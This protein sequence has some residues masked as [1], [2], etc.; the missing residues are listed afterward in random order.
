MNPARLCPKL[1]SAR[2]ALALAT[3]VSPWAGQSANAAAYLWDS[4][5]GL[6]TAQ[7]GGGTWDAT[8]ANW[9]NAG[10]DVVWA[11]ANDAT[12]G[13]GTDGTYAVSVAL[14]PT[15]NSLIFNNS[16]YT[17]SAAAPQTVTVGSA[18]AALVLG[19]GKS[20]TIGNNVTVTTS[21]VNQNSVI[22]GAGTLTIESGGTLR[23]AGTVNTNILSINGTTV[24]VK[25]G[26]TV[27][28][29]PLVT[30]GTALFLNGTMNVT[31]GT[32]TVPG[33]LGLGQSTG[34]AAGT[35][36]I[37]SGT[38]TANSSNGLRIGGT[39]GT[40][41]GGT[42]NL[43]GGT[44]AALM[45]FKGAGTVT[46]SVL[47]LNGGT[48]QATAANTTFISA[49]ARAN[50]RNGG[51]LINSNGFN[52]T[53]P[54]ALLHSNVG[55]DAPTDGGLVKSGSGTLTLNGLNTYNGGTTVNGG[56]VQ[57][58]AG[59][60]PSAGTITINGGGALVASGGF[61]TVAAVLASPNVSHGSSGAVALAGA[62]SENISF[63]SFSNLMLG[64]S[65]AS[66]Y[67]GTLTPAGTTYRL[68][69]GGSALTLANLNALT[70]ANDVVIGAAG[71]TGTVVLAT[72]NDYTGSTTITSGTLQLGDGVS[73]GSIGSTSS[74]V[75]NGT[76][77]FNTVGSQATGQSISGTGSL[78]KQGIGTLTLS[79]ASNYS[80]TTTISGG[81]LLVTNSGALGTSG[82]TASVT[83]AQL[84]LSDNVSL[85]N[86]VR[87]TSSG[88]GTT[89]GILK[90]ISGS[91]TLSDFGFSGT[92][93]TR[94]HV[95]AGST[96]LMPN[97]FATGNVSSFRVI[98]AGTLNLGGNNG[99]A[100]GAAQLFLLGDGT[101]PGPTVRAGND[102][103][104][105][106][107]Q[108][109]FQAN[110]ASTVQSANAT[111]RALPNALS[112]NGATATLGAP[113]TGDLTFT[114]AATLVVSL[115]LS[116]N[117]TVTTLGGVIGETGGARSLTKSGP[118]KL[119]LTNAGN[120]YTG[121]TTVTAGTLL[122]G[123]ATALGSGPVLVT[124]GSFDLNGLTLL[125]ANPVTVGAAGAVTG[126]GALALAGTVEG[127]L[128]PGGTGAAG[129]I[130]SNGALTLGSA[131]VCNLEIGGV[132]AGAFD[133]V[134][135]QSGITLAGTVNVSL[136]NGFAPVAGNSFDLFAED[137]AFASTAILNLPALP[138]GLGWNTAAFAT[139][140]VVSVVTVATPDPLPAWASGFSL[141]GA[142][143]LADADPDHDGISNALEYALGTSPTAGNGAA[144]HGV[145]A[146]TSGQLT[147]AYRRPAGGVAGVTY[148]VE[149]RTSDL[150][151]G[152][153][154]WTAGLLGT[155]YSQSILNNGDSTETVTITFT[156]PVGSGKKFGRLSVAF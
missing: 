138:A 38:V 127:T 56:A 142:A 65:V 95:V 50:V 103:A 48:L 125:P 68:G 109:S 130:V 121:G 126:T 43:E 133:V 81:I 82:V 72:S 45:V 71:S 117:N 145:G 34:T 92:G 114:G 33:T 112:F 27:S 19:T 76:L 84:Q 137:G 17:L 25:T 86:V 154:G 10:A 98:G 22:S 75:N 152:D 94:I 108:I 26:G 96:L 87:L 101:N 44:L 104:F 41:A 128:V 153:T 93:G 23:G 155:D 54:Q 124:G 78:R 85:A 55:G 80:G 29:L 91:N 21:S 58:G 6:A 70:G 73:D 67:T 144:Y 79:G 141:S 131:A 139:S 51:A 134:E 136:I 66:T 140:G 57:F 110:S 62:S 46:T 36:T 49:L 61:A 119:V 90:N 149:F 8:T 116:V 4:D 37:S 35:L 53:A 32:V 1:S 31:G 3:L 63:G 18:T 16:G 135:A 60:V 129:R 15:A 11:N 146:A 118:G 123:A 97:D 59:A 69:G 100:I 5:L 105:G 106:A 13:A 147:L 47:N 40:T 111:A 83:S 89:D 7:D 132:G 102:G 143:A 28:T 122:A 107:G 30:N 12:F 150:V 120:A 9:I 39:T 20:A 156:A 52:L 24:V 99:G 113:S 148:G 14:T 151:S 115:D 74:L 88:P 64:A 77:T 2:A 42:V